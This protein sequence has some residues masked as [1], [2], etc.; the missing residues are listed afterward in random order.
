MPE[1]LRSRDCVL[2]VRGDIYAVTVSQ[3]MVNNGWP[4]GQ[5]VEWVDVSVDDRVVTYSS[6]RFGGFLLWGSDEPADQYIAST[7]QFPTYKYGVMVSGSSLIS[8]SSYERYTYASRIGGGPLVPLLYGSQEELYFSLRGLFTK[9]DELSLTADPR[10]PALPVGF[11]AQVPSTIN[12]QFLG[13]QTI[14]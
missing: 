2:L 8:T 4:G 7:R 1:I 3:A 11:V 6:G 10:A 13:I 9:E 14:I 12:R 5:G